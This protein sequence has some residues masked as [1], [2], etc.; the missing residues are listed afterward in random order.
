MATLHDFLEAT[1][2]R[3]LISSTI[4]SLDALTIG[5]VTTDS[6]QVR[7][8]DVFWAL[9]GGKRDGHEFAADAFQRGAAGA[10][11]SRLM[12]IPT[13]RW[14][15]M[16]ADTQ[17]ALR[18]WASW[19][20]RHFT[21]LVIA[22]T[23]SVGKTTTRQ[24]IH[25]VLS[26]RLKGT[27][28][29]RNFNNHLGLPLSMLAIEPEHDY[30]VLELGASRPGEIKALA[31]L[32]VPKIGVITQLGEA[33]LAGFGSRQGVAEAKAEL[34][35]ALPPDGQAI[36]AD[37]PALRQVAH[38][39]QARIT[40]VGAGEQCDLRAIGVTTQQGQLNFRVVAGGNPGREDLRAAVGYKFTVPVWGRHHL[41]GALVA[42]AV[43][44]TLGLD[45]E[46]IADALACFQSLPMRCEVREIR[47]AT[48]INDTYNASPTAM[49]AALELLREMEAPGRRIVVCGDMAEL[50]TQSVALHWQLGKQVA[51]VAAADLLIAC[52]QF[53]RHVVAGA[54]AGGMAA[55]RTIACQ[56]SEEI[57]PHLGQAVVPGDVVLVK[58][59]RV[60]GMERVVEALEQ[61]P[62]RRSA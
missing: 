28:S 46:Q 11:V 33:H 1:G 45:L 48:V 57:L 58:G 31:E 53:A 35:A 9:R 21:G 32:C 42:V 59:S 26:A 24:M 18:R 60:M 2:G 4:G 30:A 17:D 39:C 55:G 62:R 37:D 12:D 27:A 41:T 52:G 29:P 38:D 7:N 5:A 16:V 22:V 34:L 44:R 51:E 20:R 54:R 15:L 6:R 40:W 10:V 23:G 13:G 3:V 14:A 8:G 61:F 36:L 19:K 56:Q 50:G 47:G 25:T 49:C 43:G